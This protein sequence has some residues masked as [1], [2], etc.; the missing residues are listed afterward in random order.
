[1]NKPSRVIAKVAAFAAFGALWEIAPLARW[2]NPVLL[3]PLHKAAREIIVHSG[4]LQSALVSFT[5]MALG[6]GLASVAGLVLGMLLGGWFPTLEAFLS[7]PLEALSQISPMLL[8]HAAILFFGIG[9][10]PKA[11]IVF[12]ASV[13]PVLFSAAAGVKAAGAD[14]LHWAASLGSSRAYIF[15]H[16][17]LPASAPLVF[18]GLRQGAQSAFTILVAA[19]MMGSQSGL[20]YWI[21]LSRDNFRLARMYAGVLSIAVLSL[22]FDGLLGIV[23]HFA[24]KNP[25]IAGRE[26]WV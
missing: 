8:F 12:W 24:D 21:L 19:E 11:F 22:I 10:G 26:A 16:V 7:S 18:S 5:R 15:L 3:P 2:V 14:E 4:F 25:K 9:E 6:F 13:W 20:G 1:M 17:A 23:Q